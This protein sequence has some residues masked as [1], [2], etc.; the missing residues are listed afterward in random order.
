MFIQLYVRYLDI[1]QAKRFHR[2][3]SFWIRQVDFIS[4]NNRTA[5]N[6]ILKLTDIALMSLTGSQITEPSRNK[7]KSVC[8]GMKA[9]LER[10]MDILKQTVIHFISMRIRL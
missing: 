8:R 6:D 3:V 4:K 10:I 5:P 7:V 2:K 9:E 1:T